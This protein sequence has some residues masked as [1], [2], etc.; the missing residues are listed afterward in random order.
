MGTINCICMDTYIIQRNT[1]DKDW[2]AR[3]YAKEAQLI[4]DSNFDGVKIDNC[5]DDQGIGF[6][7]IIQHFNASGKPILVEDCN[8]G[9][10]HGPPR[11]LPTD[12]HGWCPGN[13]FR[14][15]GDIVADFGNTMEHLQETIPYQNL[16]DPISRPG[17][18]A[19]P[20]MLEV[21]NLK[22]PN[23]FTQSRTH[24]GAWCIVSAP[25]YLSLDLTDDAK[26]DA[27]WE[28]LSNK[29]AIAV[30]QAWH[31]HP[32]RLVKDGGPWQLWAKRLADGAQAA[33]LLNRGSSE[34]DKVTVPLDMLSSELAKGA[35]A[36]DVWA[37]RDMH[38]DN[39]SVWTVPRLNAYDSA[40]VI[41][42]PKRAVALV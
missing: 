14:T 28:I 1:I 30:N 39:P 17:C 7:F 37:R 12:P 16:T 13:F 35:T 41:F 4:L 26:I 6:N 9:H 19:H 42:K 2:P 3:V 31:G 23:S 20:D 33:L 29:E 15:G 36:R 21:G 40:F 34:V 22:G 11:G 5:G 24:F 25:L 10:G 38:L 18:W 8:Q 27:V 32:G